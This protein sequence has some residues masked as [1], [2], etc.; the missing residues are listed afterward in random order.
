LGRYKVAHM[1]NPSADVTW[2]GGYWYAYGS[3]NGALITN[4]DGDTILKPNADT[5]DDTT[6]VAKLM[7]DGTL[8][9]DLNCQNIVPATADF[10]AGI[11]CDLAGDLE[12]P[13][14]YDTL[15]F[16]GDSTNYWDLSSMDT[17]KITMRGAGAGIFFFQSQAVTAKFASPG[18]AYGFHGFAVKFPDT[19][20]ATATTYAF[21]V[22]DFV[23]SSPEAQSVPW[24]TASHAISTF[25]IEVDA[26]NDDNLEIEVKKIEFVGIDTTNVFPFLTN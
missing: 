18:D 2:G 17:V 19:M 6:T 23:T 1:G 20:P 14:K 3:A 15:K 9:A 25:A 10:W 7:V 16:P 5:Q 21:A 12:N 8:Y 24:S 13:W 4:S 22:K 11:A 26:E